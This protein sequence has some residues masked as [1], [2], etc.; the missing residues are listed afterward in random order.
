MFNVYGGAIT[1]DHPLGASG[2]R[3]PV[4]FVYKMNRQ[5][6]DRGLSTMYVGYG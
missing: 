3:L 1:I 2:A 6:V 5:D 4:T